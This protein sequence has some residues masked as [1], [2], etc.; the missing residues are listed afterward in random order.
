MDW[1]WFKDHFGSISD[2]LQAIGT[3]VALI[4]VRIAYR[5]FKNENKKRDEELNLITQQTYELKNLYNIQDT[6]RRSDIRPFF[7][8]TG[9]S[10]SSDGCYFE[11]NNRGK[12]AYKL[13]LSLL[14]ESLLNEYNIDYPTNIEFLDTGTL[15]IRIKYK[16]N[17]L[18]SFQSLKDNIF[19]FGLMYE[20]EDRNIYN[21][22]LKV[23]QKVH[24][25]TEQI[26]IT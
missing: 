2:L 1:L 21:Q 10:G 16:N 3:L 17:D 8:A 6:I 22:D 14:S 23:G 7:I 11:F 24:I 19:E 25:I 26:P 5:Q 15:R 4:G 20:D 18:L 13:C 12:R 9:R